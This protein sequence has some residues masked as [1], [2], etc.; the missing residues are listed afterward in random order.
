MLLKEGLKRINERINGLPV[1]A[2]LLLIIPR[3]V[4]GFLLSFSFGS[5]KFGMPWSPDHLNL[6]LF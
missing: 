4:C 6:G 5:D 1:F 2:S 3:L